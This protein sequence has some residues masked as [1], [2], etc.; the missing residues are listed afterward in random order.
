MNQTLELCRWTYNETLA[1]R[2]NAY[3]E[4]G[5]TISK[6]ETHD[7]LPKWKED[8]PELK[9]VFS[10]TLQNVQERVDLA[11]KAFFR[12]LSQEISLDIQDSK[13]EDGM[14]LSAILRWDS[15]LRMA[16]LSFPR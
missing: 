1:Y 7:L 9:E 10:Q 13:E 4:N 5:K 6:Y 16:F 15:S 12:R 3:E 14:T 8:K 11:F 2:K